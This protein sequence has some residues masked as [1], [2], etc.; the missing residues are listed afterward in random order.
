VLVVDVLVVVLVSVVDV[1]ELVL[2]LELVDVV[3]VVGQLTGAAASFRWKVLSS[4]P[5]FTTV[6]PN[7]VQYCCAFKVVTTATGDMVPLRSIAT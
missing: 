2:V 7:S 6:P 3:V 4:L 1:V 5:S